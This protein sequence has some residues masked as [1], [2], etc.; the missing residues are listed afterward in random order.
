MPFAATWMELETLIWSEVSQR[1][2][3]YLEYNIWHKGTFPKKRKSWTWEDRLVVANG[4]G[5]SGVDWELEVNV[6]KLLPLEWISNEILLCSPG[7][8]V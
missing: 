5:G 1:N 8:Y 6:C 7:N 2:H 3:L 4:W